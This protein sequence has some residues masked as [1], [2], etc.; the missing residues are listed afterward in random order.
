VK[1]ENFFLFNNNN[2]SVLQLCFALINEM[3]HHLL[4]EELRAIHS[5]LNKFMKKECLAFDMIPYNL[6]VSSNIFN[7]IKLYEFPSYFGFCKE[8]YCEILIYIIIDQTDN[9]T[10]CLDCVKNHQ[11]FYDK[12]QNFKIF[13]RG[14]IDF[15]KHF[16]LFSSKYFGKELEGNIS[17][18]EDIN[19]IGDLALEN[20]K[21][22]SNAFQ[23]NDMMKD[24]TIVRMIS[25][26]YLP[27][28]LDFYI[29]ILLDCLRLLIIQEACLF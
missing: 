28:I 25:L 22:N 4:D 5:I 19:K 1:S 21:D 11:L 15:F 26:F 16:L 23:N 8:C 7:D 18:K 14:S 10:Y 2:I 3:Q 17:N 24:E 6:I 20:M 13:N 29:D 9:S 27:K 12:I